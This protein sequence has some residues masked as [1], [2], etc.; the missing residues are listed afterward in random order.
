LTQENASSTSIKANRI[1]SLSIQKA[2]LLV[3]DGSNGKSTLINLIKAFTGHENVSA[4]S[5]QELENNRFSKA[6]LYNKLVNLYADLLDGALKTVGTFK[7]LTGSDPIKGERKFQN[8]FLFKNFAK[9]IFLANKVPKV[10]EDRDAF[11]RRWT[12][13]TFPNLQS[14]SYRVSI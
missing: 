11:F 10:F 5:L 1:K 14:P 9:L 2:L 6:D 4:V 12:I 7:M 13:L 3:G 8:S